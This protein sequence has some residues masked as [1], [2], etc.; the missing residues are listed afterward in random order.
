MKRKARNKKRLQ[1]HLKQVNLYAA[2][3]DIGSTSHF[4][5]VPPSLDDRPIREYSCFTVDLEHMADWLKEIGI[6]TIA[7]ESTG[8]YWIPAFELLEERG[9]EVFLVNPR[10]LKNVPGRKTDVLDCQ[11]LQQLH[12]FGLLRG[13]FRPPSE[14]C[15]FRTYM[16]Q[17]AMLVSSAATHIQ[18]MQKALRQMNLLLDNVVSDITGKTGMTI[19]RSILSGQR[20]P[21]ILA[22]HRDIHCKNSEEVIAKSLKGHYKKE[23]LFSLRQAVELY[24]FYQC[25]IANCDQTIETTLSEIEGPEDLDDLPPQKRSYRRKDKVLP[26]DARKDLYSITGVDI[27]KIDGIKETTALK[28]ISEIGTD[29]SVWPTVKNFASWLC[30]S[31]GN[32][33]TGGKIISSKTKTSANRAAMAFRMAAF[34]LTKS[35]SALGAFY[36]RKRS[37][38]GAPKAITA[39]AHKIARLVYSMLKHGAEYVDQGQDYYE[40][41]YHERIIKNLRKRAKDLGFEMVPQS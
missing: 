8:V 19:I 23:H 39:T 7:M 26:F 29:M 22:K 25:Q 40:K 4:V 20:D 41:K 28:I 11:W 38:L 35:K 15:A 31:P 13:A 36:R 6:S 14:I 24:D 18:H 33:I 30:L 5:A 37:Q 2:G 16:R 32:K 21:E 9:F 17:R 34:S 27:T 10:H 12:S 3:I 1:D